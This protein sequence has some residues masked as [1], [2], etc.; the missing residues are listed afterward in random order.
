MWA[1]DHPARCFVHLVA[2]TDWEPLTGQPTPTTRPS[3]ATYRS[4][5]IPW[6]DYDAPGATRPGSSH[7]G[8]LDSVATIAE[9]RRQ[10][11]P[12]NDT[13]PIDRVIHLGRRGVR[14]GEWS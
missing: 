12:D 10:S 7:L 9:Q 1:L 6:F 2:A 4:N 14:P 5:G 8:G 13:V 11:L 3:P